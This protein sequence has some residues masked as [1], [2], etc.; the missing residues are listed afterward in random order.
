MKPRPEGFDY[1]RPDAKRHR[2]V[3]CNEDG[4][5]RTGLKPIRFWGACS[6][7]AWAIRCPNKCCNGLKGN[8]E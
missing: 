5:N 1:S 3:V 6:T 8:A 2:C 7:V 4:M